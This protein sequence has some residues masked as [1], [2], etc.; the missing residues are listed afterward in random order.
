MRSPLI[1]LASIAAVS[2]AATPKSFLFSRQTDYADLVPVGCVDQ[3]QVYVKYVGLCGDV[4]APQAG[5]P[6]MEICKPDEW[7]Q[8]IPCAMCIGKLSGIDVSDPAYS[9]MPI[10]C[11]NPEGYAS[12]TYISSPENTAVPSADILAGGGASSGV[13]APSMDA[14]SFT[15]AD[16]SAVIAPSAA[17][18]SKPTS[19]LPPRSSTNHATSV[20]ASASATPKSEAGKVTVSMAVLG[21]AVLFASTF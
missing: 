16:S 19:P 15:G 21:A 7:A 2:A 6:C 5:S 3:C 12:M 9:E 17:A 20:S 1:L 8:V 14:M 18:P 11:T 4:V 13:A 10:G